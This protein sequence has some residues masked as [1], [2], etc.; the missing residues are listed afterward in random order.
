MGG[1]ISSKNVL[2]KL[3]HASSTANANCVTS[4]GNATRRWGP[5]SFMPP[6]Y[7]AGSWMLWPGDD[8]SLG[9]PFRFL[10]KDDLEGFGKR[11]ALK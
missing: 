6:Q 5:G 8:L 7:L 4:P 2:T 11:P 3:V 10:P 1:M 9:S